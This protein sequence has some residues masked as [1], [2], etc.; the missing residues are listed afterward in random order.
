VQVSSRR[1]TPRYPVD[2]H[3]FA[4]INGHTVRLRNISRSGVAINGTG[5]ASGTVYLLERHLN[6]RHVTLTVEILDG[7]DDGLMHAR[8]AEPTLDQQRLIDHYIAELG[9]AGGSR[10]FL[11]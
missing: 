2:T 4:S 10:G 7:T 1:A 11:R 9:G 6:R 3:L 5:L 8:F